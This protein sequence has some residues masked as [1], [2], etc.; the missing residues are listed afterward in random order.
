MRISFFTYRLLVSLFAGCLILSEPV[1]AKDMI[2]YQRYTMQDGLSHRIICSFAQDSIGYIWMGTWN[3]VCR[4]DGETF[5]NFN[6]TSDG[7]YIGRV[8][9]VGVTLD[10]RIWA[11][12]QNDRREYILNEQTGQLDPI[13][14]NSVETRRFSPVREPNYADSTGLVIIH[15]SVRYVI[16]YEGLGLTA[17]S[18]YVAMLDRQGN[19]WANFDDALY[20]ISFG[21]TPY[22]ATDCVDDN[23]PEE[24][25]GDEIRSMLALHDG[26]YLLGCKTGYVYK[27]SAEWQLLGYL[28]A[29]GKVVRQKTPFGAVVYAMK[30]DDCGRLWLGC[31]GQ[32]LYC[33]E[34]RA[35]D[36]RA[37]SSS[38][39]RHYVDPTLSNNNIFDLYVVG[40]D[41]VMVATWNG[42]VQTI[43]INR[44][45]TPASQHENEDIRK[46]R[47][48]CYV[49]PELYILCSTR[50][51]VFVDGSL[52]TLAQTGNTDFSYVQQGADGRFYASTLSG[53]VFTFQ[54]PE[55]ISEKSLQ[56]VTL[57]KLDLPDED[58]IILAIARDSNG[59]LWFVSDNAVQYY[60]PTT[61]YSRRIDQTAF[62]TTVT[63][64]EA[65]PLVL[66][67]QIVL[68]TTFGRMT[69]HL[70]RPTGYTP[71]LLLNVPDTIDVGWG[72]AVN[73]IRATAIDYRLPRLVQYGWRSK[74]DSVWQ[75]LGSSGQLPIG[76]LSPGTHIFEVRSTDA[77][78]FIWSDNQRDICIRVSLTWWQKGVVILLVLVFA[79]LAYWG[80]KANRRIKPETKII[81]VKGPAIITGIQPS[82]PI[83]EAKDR[84]FLALV[85]KTTEEHIGDPQ[86]DVD[87]L[88]DYMHISRTILYS[89]FREM[90][91]TTPAAFINDIRL[92][93]SV[94]LLD[95]LQH[96]V[97][98]VAFMCG[99]NDPKYY[100]RIFKQKMGIT[101]NKYME[102]LA[103]S[104]KE[105]AE[106]HDDSESKDI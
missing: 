66:D 55:Q 83:V 89:R 16:P 73:D 86:L 90:L 3:G 53:G 20:Q 30:Q 4:F 70:N 71:D 37:E 101:P 65:R 7:E 17:N 51:L 48:I 22:E 105:D 84:Q 74:S 80:W 58:D 8:S 35:L 18:H 11:V 25:Y 5:T 76:R 36:S 31:R 92:K 63:F 34:S 78:G 9:Q 42:G 40:Y 49:S 103:Q 68:G 104:K 54:L 57:T 44:Q 43:S 91:D 14:L 77:Q 27:Y 82:K 69:I 62:G 87:K 79:L 6:A 59:Q 39:I 46:V 12:R 99:Y 38:K 64:G 93:R 67:G 97:N 32:G 56:E 29:E 2:H 75:M 100:T 72:T 24:K 13:E 15:D 106:S 52:R 94:Q 26:G 28:T 81:K 21:Q 102:Q 96:R 23:A 19:I 1:S 47:R 88:A 60:D 85:T 41:T 50:G 10:N 95:T 61:G 45:G 33:I 98:E